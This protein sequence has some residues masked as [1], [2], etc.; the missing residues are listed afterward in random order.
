MAGPTSNKAPGNRGFSHSRKFSLSREEISDR[1]AILCHGGGSA[2]V[3]WI[4]DSVRFDHPAAYQLLALLPR[5]IIIDAWNAPQRAWIASTLRLI[6]AE[7]KALR[8]GSETIIT[9]LADILVIQAIRSWIADDPA[10]QTGW[11]GALQDTQ[12]GR[13]SYSSSAIRPVGG[14]WPHWQMKSRCR[15]RHVRRPLPRSWAS[16]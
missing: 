11:L 12:I 2:G 10:A 14:R 16:Q 7:A 6:A 3:N 4:C 5:T 13:A 8:P 1:Y 9:R 15:A